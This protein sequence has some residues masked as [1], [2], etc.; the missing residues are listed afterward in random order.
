MHNFNNSYYIFYISLILVISSMSFW[1][2]DIISEGIAKSSYRLNITKAI[3]GEVLN[4]ALIDYKNTNNITAYANKD[5]LGYYLAG[6]L[7]GV[8]AGHLS[9]PS[10]GKTTLNRVLNPRIVFTSHV[11]NLGMTSSH[12]VLSVI[13]LKLTRFHIIFRLFG[14]ISK[15]NLDVSKALILALLSS[16]EISSENMLPLYQK[17]LFV[18]IF[19]SGGW[20]VSPRINNSLA[21]IKL[22]LPYF[23]Q[24]YINYLFDE[25]SLY[26]D[27]GGPYRYINDGYSKGKPADVILISTKWLHCLTSFYPVF[28]S[29]KEKVV[30]N[31]IYDILTPL[32]LF[33]WVIGSGVKLKGR[34]LI[35]ST[36]GFNIPDTVKLMNVLI[37]KY[38]LR[39]NLL[40]VN[41][42]T[43]IY[44]YRSSLE[45]LI[46]IIKLVLN[47]SARN[48]TKEILSYF[49]DVLDGL[50]EVNSAT[51]YKFDA[52]KLRGKSLTYYNLNKVRTNS[53]N[54]PMARD[55]TQRRTISSLTTEVK[56]KLNAWFVTGFTDAEGCFGVYLANNEKYSTGWNVLVRFE[57]HLHVRDRQLLEEIREFFEGVGSITSTEDR[58]SYIVRSVSELEIIVKHFDNYPLLSKKYLDFVLFKSV[59]NIIKE[60][61][62]T[63]AEISR[64]VAIKASMNKGLSDKLKN[65]FPDIIPAERPQADNVL[66]PNPNWLVGFIEGEGCFFIDIAKST[67]K[68]GERVQLTFQITQHTRDI[69]LLQSI[70]S[71]LGSGRIKEFSGKNFVNVIIS[72]F[73]GIDEII[74]P[75]LEKYPLRGHKLLNYKDFKKAAELI[76]SKAHLTKE[77]LLE[78][79]KIKEGMNTLRK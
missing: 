63:L 47:T 5:N 73:S 40:I 50:L 49:S 35:L 38:S 46:R 1:F 56:S 59:I 32:V 52:T 58:A 37:I 26:C 62:I 22:R 4:K 61:K 15:S 77:G 42:K 6:L 68:L 79:K 2:R 74:L 28:Y 19:L 25:I 39:C 51:S 7:E 34:G 20:L 48:I 31:N 55:I 76:K 17:S 9:L 72:K 43:R 69:I 75:L 24:E 29:N 23:K 66:I 3:S 14:Q 44:I 45:D 54:L 57:L 11:D 36:D 65:S 18:G 53:L 21:K 30:P 71:F 33:H 12:P 10:L 16:K 67:G 8:H 41:N 64:I 13:L 78:I 60:G 70:I 27:K